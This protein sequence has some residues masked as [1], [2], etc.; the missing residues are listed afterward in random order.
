M[1]EKVI[2]YP[3]TDRSLFLVDYLKDKYEIIPVEADGSGYSSKDLGYI[4]G[5][6]PI[7]VKVR[8][9]IEHLIVCSGILILTNDF[10]KIRKYEELY[11]RIL[12]RKSEKLNVLMSH[13][14]RE[15][16]EAIE[17]RAVLYKK[18]V[19]KR[20]E[21]P[22]IA[23]GGIVDDYVNAEIV[24]NLYER[25]SEIYSVEAIIKESEAELIG[26]K[27][28]DSLIYDTGY[29]EKEKILH[30]NN[31]IDEVQ[32]KKAPDVIILQIPG[33]MMRI[34]EERDN[35]FG[36]FYY[37]VSQAV[38]IDFFV[39]T[40][41]YEF[42]DNSVLRK[43][44]DDIVGKYN[45]NMDVINVSNKIIDWDTEDFKE[46]LSFCYRD[47][48]TME[49][50]YMENSACIVNVKRSLKEYDRIMEE[51]NIKLEGNFYE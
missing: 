8:N 28:W 3:I 33:G 9:D 38:N 25:L 48:M 32:E 29:G 20:I 5:M 22:I 47:A 18:P 51:I 10:L 1:K 13:E 42:I 36:I 7:G 45:I 27:S 14:L 2:I 4:S 37:Y 46:E 50:K 26:I 49:T 17:K 15:K 21:T 24:I 31:T 23:V 34:N 41:P 6:C 16:L 44:N 19:F 43:I 40:V 12:H 39:C 35:D 30:I 11:K